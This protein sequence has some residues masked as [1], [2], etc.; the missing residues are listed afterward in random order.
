MS[1]VWLGNSGRD[2]WLVRMGVMAVK[3]VVVVVAVVI[4]IV[5]W[6]KE[7]AV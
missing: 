2:D 7:G 1:C 6:T 5:V 4:A 3:W